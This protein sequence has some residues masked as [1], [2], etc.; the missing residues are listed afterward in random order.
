MIAD[1]YLLSRNGFR[2]H[3]IMQNEGEIVVTFPKA[4]HWGFNMGNNLNEAFNFGTR[5]WIKEF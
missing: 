1:P 5:S 4:Y 2:V 3:K